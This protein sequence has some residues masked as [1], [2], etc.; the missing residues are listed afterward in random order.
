MSQT[1]RKEILE[2]LRRRYRS[3]GA[4]HKHKLLDQAQE[5]LGYHRKSAV[6]ALNAPQTEPAPWINPG[7]PVKYEPKAFGGDDAGVAPGL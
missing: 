5:L 2:R 7:R 3:A 6:R 4:E 1:T